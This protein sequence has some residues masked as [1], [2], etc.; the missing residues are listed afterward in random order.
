MPLLGTT[1]TVYRK[2][3]YG[4][5]FQMPGEQ[6][7]HAGQGSRSA[8][9]RIPTRSAVLVHFVRFAPADAGLSKN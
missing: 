3:T 6:F 4:I 7:V 9:F 5:V 1:V 2:G 8:C